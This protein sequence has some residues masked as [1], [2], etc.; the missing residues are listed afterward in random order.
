MVTDRRACVED[1]SAAPGLAAIS[2][3]GL[4]HL[5]P[6]GAAD[7]RGDTGGPATNRVRRK[8]IQPPPPRSTRGEGGSAVVRANPVDDSLARQGPVVDMVRN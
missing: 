6:L 5:E 4:V 3:K 2:A 7:T 1:A 8:A